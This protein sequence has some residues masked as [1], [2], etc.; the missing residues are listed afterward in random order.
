MAAPL[1]PTAPQPGLISE[2]HRPLGAKNP[3]ERGSPV[4]GSS[5]LHTAAATAAAT[6]ASSSSL[7]ASSPLSSNTPSSISMATDIAASQPMSLPGSPPPPQ[8]RP[9]N[10]A[11]ALPPPVLPLAPSR[12]SIFAS[13]RFAL[14]TSS[15]VCADTADMPPLLLLAAPFFPEAAE[16]KAASSS[17]GETPVPRPGKKSRTRVAS[18][19][20]TLWTLYTSRDDFDTPAM[21]PH[22]PRRAQSLCARKEHSVCCTAAGKGQP[23]PAMSQAHTPGGR[24]CCCC[25]C[26]CAADTAAA[27]LGGPPSHTERWC[28]LPQLRPV[29]RLSVADAAVDGERRA[30]S[31]ARR[32]AWRIFSGGGRSLRSFRSRRW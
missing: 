18:A 25:R 16:P 6:S 31:L 15:R 14:R 1:A 5:S 27:L 8:F 19:S 22:W 30:Q 11:S 2:G 29:C 17:S 21:P 9:S 24:C 12:R 10:F 23:N 20:F 32:H 26:C 3:P 4:A 7:S 13:L 28:R